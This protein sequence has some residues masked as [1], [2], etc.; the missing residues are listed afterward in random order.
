M[1][2]P[3]GGVAAGAV[4]FAVTFGSDEVP[5]LLGQGFPATLPVVAFQAYSDTDLTAR[6]RAYAIAVLITF[7]VTLVVL[8]YA[9]LTERV[10]RPAQRQ[11]RR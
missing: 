6:P 7:L 9:F 8:A 1:G 2:V 10:L 11:A 5:L 3:G 4:V